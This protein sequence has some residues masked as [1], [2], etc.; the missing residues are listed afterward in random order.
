M[1]SFSVIVVII[2]VKLFMDSLYTN[3]P[4]SKVTLLDVWSFTSVSVMLFRLRYLKLMPRILL[5]DSC[6]KVSGF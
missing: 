2:I 6:H 3:I 4:K 1:N 5:N